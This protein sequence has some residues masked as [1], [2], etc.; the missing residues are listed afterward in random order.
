VLRL[1]QGTLSLG[2]IGQTLFVSRN[3]IKS[4]TSAIYRKLGTSTRRDT[5]QRGRELRIL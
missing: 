3:T 5:I 2:D 4:H 1:L